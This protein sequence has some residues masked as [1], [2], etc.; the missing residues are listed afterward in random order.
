[1]G[2]FSQATIIFNTWILTIDSSQFYWHLTIKTFKDEGGGGV[3]IPNGQA[4]DDWECSTLS[5]MIWECVHLVKDYAGGGGVVP[6]SQAY[7]PHSDDTHPPLMDMSGKSEHSTMDISWQ[8]KNPPMDM[9]GKKTHRYV[10]NF[11][12][13]QTPGGTICCCFGEIELAR[14]PTLFIQTVYKYIFLLAPWQVSPR[15]SPKK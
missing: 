1:M 14:P 3:V 13:W 15:P 2:N 6:K 4:L 7:S 9:Y 11:G 5:W 10:C 12:L 8:A